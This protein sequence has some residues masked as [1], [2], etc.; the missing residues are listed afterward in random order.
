MIDAQETPSFTRTIKTARTVE[1]INEAARAGLRPL[2]KPVVPSKKIRAKF[3]VL[4]HRVTGEVSV[5]ADYRTFLDADWEVAIDWTRHY[6]HQW[7]LPFAAYLLPADLQVGERVLL[8]DLIED[9]VGTSWN[10]GDAYR[11]ESCTATWN[12]KDF[13][14]DYSQ[15][16][17]RTLVIG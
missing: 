15:D 12:G 17:D 10:Q 6:P 3:Q 14:L 11:L 16:R 1:D 2:I 8:E 7:P 4:Q 9:L 5:V 13:D